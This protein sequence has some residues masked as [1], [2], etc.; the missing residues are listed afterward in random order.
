MA[1]AKV[2]TIDEHIKNNFYNQA[3]FAR[4]IG[5]SPQ[6]VVK[7]K[8]SGYIV[9]DGVLCKKMRDLTTAKS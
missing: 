1:K 9:V 4:K 6:H 7:W 8:V 2:E 3:D 5:T